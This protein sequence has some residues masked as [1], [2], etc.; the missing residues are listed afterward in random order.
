[1]REWSLDRWAE[2]TQVDLTKELFRLKAE[3]KVERM[4][5]EMLHGHEDLEDEE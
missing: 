4:A 2:N 1:M 5:E 3:I